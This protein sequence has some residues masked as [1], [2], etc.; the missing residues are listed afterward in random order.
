MI[1]FNSV[2]SAIWWWLLYRSLIF[3]FFHLLI[4]SKWKR[5]IPVEGKVK[6]F[7]PLFWSWFTRFIYFYNFLPQFHL[8]TLTWIMTWISNFTFLSLLSCSFIFP[9]HSTERKR[10]RERK[11]CKKNEGK[12]FY[13]K[14]K[15]LYFPPLLSFL[16]FVPPSWAT[17][18][19]KKRKERRIKMKNASKL[20]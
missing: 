5:F 11:R 8:L 10:E 19:W 2:I 7:S 18:H 20:V 12:R 13:L 15:S 17:N 9:F 6:L 3:F 4:P 16:Y 14:H 1:F